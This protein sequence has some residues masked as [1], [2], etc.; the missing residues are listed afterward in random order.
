MLADHEPVAEVP[1]VLGGTPSLQEP[2]ADHAIVKPVGSKP[3]P[4]T[5]P[6]APVKARPSTHCAPGHANAMLDCVPKLL[7]VKVKPPEVNSTCDPPST[8]KS[9]DDAKP[10]AGARLPL[11]PTPDENVL[12]TLKTFNKLTIELGKFGKEAGWSKPPVNEIL[13][14]MKA[15]LALVAAIAAEAR[16]TTDKT[17]LS[18]MWKISDCGDGQMTKK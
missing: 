17:D 4:V 10:L 16:A 14:L 18:F 15:A 12:S 3:L 6:V 1:Q 7:T 2:C 9:S 11:P 8:E 13:P 5:I